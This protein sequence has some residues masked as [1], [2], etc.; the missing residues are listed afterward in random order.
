MPEPHA[1]KFPHP[2]RR[3]GQKRPEPESEKTEKQKQKPQDYKPYHNHQNKH[4]RHHFLLITVIEDMNLFRN[5]V[6]NTHGF[7]TASLYKNP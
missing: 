3:P 4:S 2:D 1:D 6:L 5:R 7:E